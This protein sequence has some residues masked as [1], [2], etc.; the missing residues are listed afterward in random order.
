[1]SLTRDDGI[2]RSRRRTYDRVNHKYEETILNADGSVYYHTSEDLREH[3]GR[4]SARR[5]EPGP[6]ASG[7]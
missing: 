4:G 5:R 1:M 7:D 6:P 3:S 2:E